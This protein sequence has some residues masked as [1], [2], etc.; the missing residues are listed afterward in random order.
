MSRSDLAYTLMNTIRKIEDGPEGLA[1]LETAME[2]VERLCYYTGSDFDAL[3]VEGGRLTNKPA[4]HLGNAL[5]AAST[6]LSDAV[7]AIQEYREEK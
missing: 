2:E 5:R 7:R 4:Y 1:D 3:A 6:A